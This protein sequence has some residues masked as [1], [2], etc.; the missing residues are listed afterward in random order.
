MKT[1]DVDTLVNKLA[2]NK[3]GIYRAEFTKMCYEFGYEVV[4]KAFSKLKHELDQPVEPSI[5][6]LTLI[7]KN[8]LNS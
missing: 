5:R 4:F 6:H 1:E 7:L 2:H 3:C 8:E